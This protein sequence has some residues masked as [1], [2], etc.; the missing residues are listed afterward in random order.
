M[1]QLRNM[2]LVILLYLDQSPN[3]KMTF[4]D[5]IM[6]IKSLSGNNRRAKAGNDLQKN[7]I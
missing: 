3:K 5:L 6:K 1:F 4:G 2:Y 7:I